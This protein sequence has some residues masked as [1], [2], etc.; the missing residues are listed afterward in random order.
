LA[1]RELG[2]QRLQGI[3]FAAN[4]ASVRAFLKAGYRQVEERCMNG[5]ACLIFA[6][7]CA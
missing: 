1:C 5:R 6:R 3:T 7:T 4:T 2:V